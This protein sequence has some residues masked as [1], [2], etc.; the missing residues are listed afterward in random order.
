V[1]LAGQEGSVLRT[2]FWHSIMLAA[3]LSVLTFAQAYW[4]QWMIP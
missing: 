1:G 3:A 4:L 2:T